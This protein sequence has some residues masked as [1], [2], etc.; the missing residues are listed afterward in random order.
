M[1]KFILGLCLTPFLFTACEKDVVPDYDIRDEYVG[2][3]QVND[4]CDASMNDYNIAVFKANDYDEIVFGWP[5][6]YEAG[7][8]VW[9]CYRNESY[10]SNSAVFGFFIP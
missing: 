4:A 9:Y 5:G 1:K 2:D 6:L 8:E 10:Y 7:M 3:Y